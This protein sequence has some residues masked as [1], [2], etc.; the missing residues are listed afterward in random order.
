MGNNFS[1]MIFQLKIDVQKM[2]QH[3]TSRSVA[4]AQHSL[5]IISFLCTACFSE[6]L[7]AWVEDPL[8]EEHIFCVLES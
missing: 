7:M 8:R 3:K 6:A 1:L 4:L 5:D 2:I